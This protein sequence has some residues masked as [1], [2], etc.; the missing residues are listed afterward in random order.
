MYLSQTTEFRTKLLVAIC[1]K[2][3]DQ[4]KITEGI[5]FESYP[6]TKRFLSFAATPG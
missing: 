4:P 1:F 6:S 2:L 3:T 5:S